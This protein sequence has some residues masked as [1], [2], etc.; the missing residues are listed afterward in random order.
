[1]ESTSVENLDNEMEVDQPEDDGKNETTIEDQKEE[2]NSGSE[3]NKIEISNLGRFVFGVSILE[4]VF[5]FFVISTSKTD[6]F[7]LNH[8]FYT[9]LNISNRN[10]EISSKN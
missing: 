7:K 10:Y 2:Q 8:D 6:F 4:K 1:M 3:G 5:N 9:F